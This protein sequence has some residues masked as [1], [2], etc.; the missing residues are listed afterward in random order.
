M[1]CK[2]TKSAAG[3]TD[4]LA[5]KSIVASHDAASPNFTTLAARVQV[6]Y[7]DEKKQQ[8]ITVSLRMEKDKIIW[9]KASLLGITLA[10][11]KITPQRVSYYETIGVLFSTEILAYLVIGWELK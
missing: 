11:A 5:V 1:S 4:N 3:T 7:E 10:K 8:S 9:M 6:V 2:G